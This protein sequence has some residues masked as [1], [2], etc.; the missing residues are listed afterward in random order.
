[1]KK[2]YTLPLLFALL[3]E[4]MARSLST[5]R[6]HITDS[7]SRPN[8]TCP[9]NHNPLSTPLE[10]N[11]LP[12]VYKKQHIPVP[13]SLVCSNVNLSLKMSILKDTP[14][15]YKS[16]FIRNN[17]K[18]SSTQLIKMSVEDYKKDIISVECNSLSETTGPTK[19]IAIVPHHLLLNYFLVDPKKIDLRKMCLSFF[20]EYLEVTDPFF[21]FLNDLLDNVLCGALLNEIEEKKKFSYKDLKKYLS[22]F[23]N[24]GQDK[25]SNLSLRSETIIK[26]FKIITFRKNS[27]FLL[28]SMFY[29]N[30]KKLLKSRICNEKGEIDMELFSFDFRRIEKMFSNINSLYC[31][32]EYKRFEEEGLYKK[33]NRVKSLFSNDTNRAVLP[34][35]NLTY[36]AFS[37]IYSLISRMEEIESF[38][39]NIVESNEVWV[40]ISVLS[41]PAGTQNGL[42]TSRESLTSRPFNFSIR[43]DD[44]GLEEFNNPEKFIENSLLLSTDIPEKA[45]KQITL[46]YMVEKFSYAEDPQST[47]KTE[48][49]L[50]KTKSITAKTQKKAISILG[51]AKSTIICSGNKLEDEYKKIEK[52]FFSLQNRIKEKIISSLEKLEKKIEFLEK[53]AQ[54]RIQFLQKSFKKR[55]SFQ[56]KV[57]KR[58]AKERIKLYWKK[59]EEVTSS[60]KSEVKRL[61]SIYKK[62][63][64]YAG[65][66]VS[67]KEITEEERMNSYWK[68]VDDHINATLDSL[69][70]ES[71]STEKNMES[72]WAQIDILIEKSLKDLEKK[73]LQSA[74][75]SQAA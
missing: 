53:K 37:R 40:D 25:I 57:K 19:K 8:K 49:V 71:L 66:E 27:S 60:F 75:I 28:D 48:P 38:A 47:E 5:T 68:Q 52:K 73:T 4:I 11:P 74:S 18:E 65:Q 32:I 51:K 41:F 72:Y 14:D 34:K 55:L 54:N 15:L 31:P 44:K 45:E 43:M 1:M 63:M 67:P 21:S 56:D 12:T 64:E 17:N 7:I 22:F 2:I 62:K 58:L 50:K 9:S 35:K 30:L 42:I 70:K 69:E 13:A 20:T 3:P 26:A 61:H 10:Y 24:N 39:S 23:K 46:R 33:V 16:I 29:S 59:V 6:T 36:E